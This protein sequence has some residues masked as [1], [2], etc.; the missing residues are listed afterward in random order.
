ML[1]SNQAIG[2]Q[3]MHP[4]AHHTTLGHDPAKLDYGKL[5]L[6]PAWDASTTQGH[7]PVHLNVNSAL[8]RER[9]RQP[10]QTLVQTV[11][12]GRAS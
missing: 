8:G 10:V 9:A 7:T 1:A 4:G 6:N 2:R 5:G 3:N 12:C 11:T